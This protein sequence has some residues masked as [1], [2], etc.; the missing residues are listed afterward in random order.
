MDLDLLRS[1]VVVAEHGA[2]TEAAKVLGVSQ[3]ALSRRI[4]QLEEALQA[5]LLERSRRGAT[6]TEMGRLTVREGRELLE[7]YD[8]LR[9]DIAAHVHH[10]AGMVRIGG[11][12]T[13]VSFLL[14]PSIAHFR[15]RHPGILFQLKEASSR[16]IEE[17][18]A[19]E[20]LELGIVTLPTAHTEL[21]V[22]RLCED[23]IVLV[24]GR[25]HPLA[26]RRR[27][28][29]SGLDGQDLVG[30]EAASAIRRLIDGALREAG[31]SVRVIMEL[32]SI[33]AILRMVVTM[34][35]LAFV[36]E[37]GLRG[38]RGVRVVPLRGLSIVR[39]LA[40]IQKRG[41]PLSPAG[42]AFVETLH[43]GLE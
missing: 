36:S 31:V 25:D 14:P 30:F 12:A 11:G 39:S 42:A 6:L 32:R 37:L 15:R 16:E 1:L 8:R 3:S 17:D 40:L 24:A 33:P 23:R 27:P 20:R 5:P 43:M 35:G 13:A 41:R 18:V 2:I 7:R 10:Q 34:Q 4:Q 29:A 21:E 28:A 22:R 9:G 19:T 38:E 26:C